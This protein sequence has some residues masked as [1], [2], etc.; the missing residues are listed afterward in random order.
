MVNEIEVCDVIESN[1][2]AG[3]KSFEVT[4]TA[5]DETFKA[6][7]R[8]NHGWLPP[9]TKLQLATVS[10]MDK[11]HV[12]VTNQFYAHAPLTI[13]EYTQVLDS[14]HFRDPVCRC[15]EFLT[16]DGFEIYCPNL[17]CAL[18]LKTRFERLADIQFFDFETV[19]NDRE[20]VYHPNDFDNYT[21]PF[22]LLKQGLFWGFPGLTLEE[23]LLRLNGRNTT[24]MSAFMSS[25]CNISTFYIP[26]LFKEFVE[27]GKIPNWLAEQ[28]VRSID[29]FYGYMQDSINRRDTDSP[30]QNMILAGF[31]WG[32]GLESIRPL[33]IQKIFNYEY[34]IGFKDPATIYA[35][36]LTSYQELI[37]ELE[38]H[39]LEADAIVNE[40]RRRK[41]EIR[42]IFYHYSLNKDDVTRS[43]QHLM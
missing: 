21:H 24:G 26:D 13:G 15:G 14:T 3:K 40:I 23:A 1:D 32:L 27:N 16:S 17:T 42:D 37:N 9:A 5:E 25:E 38:M 36:V 41:Y 6:R 2:C 11:V 18:T 22:R 12:V 28:A 33:T 30:T 19:S 43:F 7:Y 34:N 20:L 39:P 8:L 31:L 4:S 10:Q 35:S 29:R